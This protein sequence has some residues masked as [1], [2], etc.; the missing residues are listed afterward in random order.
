M[1][2]LFTFKV[3]SRVVNNV[4]ITHCPFVHAIIFSLENGLTKIPENNIHY[5]N[6]FNVFHMDHLTLG[7]SVAKKIL[8]KI[9]ST[10]K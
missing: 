1:K 9:C 8:K 7:I 5:R 3:S 10:I 2:R 4:D 6:A